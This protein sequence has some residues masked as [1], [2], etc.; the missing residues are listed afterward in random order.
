MGFLANLKK[1]YVVDNNDGSYLT[2]PK[3]AF[4]VLVTFEDNAAFEEITVRSALIHKAN[5]SK[6]ITFQDVVS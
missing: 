5:K 2:Y 3:D 6:V 4:G 1:N